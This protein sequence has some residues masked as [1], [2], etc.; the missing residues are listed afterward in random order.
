MHISAIIVAATPFLFTRSLVY[1]ILLLILITVDCLKF[2]DGLS[3]Y[4]A[5]M[6]KLQL[7]IFFYCRLLLS[8]ILLAAVWFFVLQL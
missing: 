8:F 3:L 7:L 6:V 4:S 2:R 1:Y 5:L